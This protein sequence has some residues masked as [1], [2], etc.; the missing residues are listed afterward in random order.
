MSTFLSKNTYEVNLLAAAKRAESLL[1]NAL[2]KVEVV[3]FHSKC[4]FFSIDLKLQ[5]F[6]DI[7]NN[8]IEAHRI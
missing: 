4:A 6:L 5:L 1:Q 3:I 8:R 2:L 7:C